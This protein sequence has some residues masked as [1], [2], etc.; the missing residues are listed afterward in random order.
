MSGRF[1][2]FFALRWRI[3]PFL[4]AGYHWGRIVPKDSGDSLRG[5]G[6]EGGI[7][8]QGPIHHKLYWIARV[9][10]RRISLDGINFNGQEGTL[11]SPV[12][13]ATLQ[14]GGGIAYHW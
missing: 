4:T 3:E 11:P 12:H 14:F 6:M 10:Y 13:Y 5:Q 1:F 8:V 2:P 9:I 7:G